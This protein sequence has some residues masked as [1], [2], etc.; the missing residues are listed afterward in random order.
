[1][2]P[3]AQGLLAT[4]GTLSQ[5]ASMGHWGGVPTGKRKELGGEQLRGVP[6]GGHQAQSRQAWAGPGFPA[7]VWVCLGRSFA[8]SEPQFS[9]LYMGQV[10][11][12]AGHGISG[13]KE[14]PVSGLAGA[15]L[16][17]GSRR[18]WSHI[19]VMHRAFSGVSGGSRG[20][21]RG[22]PGGQR[23]RLPSELRRQPRRGGQ[24]FVGGE[25]S[26]RREGGGLGSRETERARASK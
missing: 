8:F 6:R 17:Q 23:G 3:L 22:D 16:L 10:A 5:P 9:G 19:G 24:S 21:P 7:Y 4:H 20:R 11:P 14:R 2:P 25:R 26:G 18:K 13:T 15:G 12:L 1:M